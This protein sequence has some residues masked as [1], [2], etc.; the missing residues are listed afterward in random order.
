MRVSLKWL[1]DYVKLS[2]PAE[3]LAAKLTMSG[4]EVGEIDV[5]GATW[6]GVSVGQVKALE[7]HPDAD[8]LLLATIDIGKETITVVTGAPNLEA[9]QKVPFARVGTQL[10]DGHTGKLI[11]LKPATI[12][13][14][15]S[16]GMACSEKELGISERHEGIMVLPEEA[17]VGMPLS[18]YLGDTIIDIT[19]TPNRPDCLSVIGIAREVAALTGHEAHIPEITYEEQG[20]PIQDAASVEIDDPD[21]CS[22]YCASLV[23]GVTVGP[24]PQWMQQRII[25]SGMRPISNIV[26]ITNYV[27]MEYGQPLHAFDYEQIKERKIIVRRARDDESLYTLDGMK[28]ELNSD[29]LIIADATEPIALAGVMGGADSEVID[30]TTSILLES[31]NFNAGSIRRTSMRLGLRSEASARFERSISPELAPIALRR[32]TQ[33]LVELGGGKAARGI[34]DVYPGKSERKPILLTQERVDRILGVA[35]ETE[36]VRQVLTSLGFSSEPSGV[37][38]ELLVTVPY[39]RTDIRLA[40]DLIEEIARIIGYDE[41][42]TTMLSSGIPE[43]APAPLLSLKETIRDLLVGSG[44][45]EVITYSLVSRATLEKIDPQQKLGS[46]LRT[47][48]PMTLEQEY[49]RTSLR[50]GLLATFSANER[51][52]E[53]GIKLFEVGKIYLPKQNDLP[54]EREALA[55]ILGGTRLDRSW[56]SGE[57]TLDFFDAKGIVETVFNRLHVE[58]SF[59]PAEAQGLIPGR[60]A[61]VIVDG[62]QLGVLGEVHPKTAALFDISTEPVVLFEIDLEKLLPFAGAVPRYQP[63]PRLPAIDRDLALV[64][65][66][67][68]AANQI[69]A[70]IRSFPLVSE[71]TLFDVYSGKQVPEGKKSLAFSVR[72]RSP[73]RTLTDEEVDRTQQKILEHLEREFG[74]TLRS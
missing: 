2:V 22:R 71:V 3:E 1:K 74:A 5:V 18:Q 23:T 17:P 24:S 40:D 36:R 39:W 37:S 66:A 52:E 70:I 44:M 48:N 34:I 7:K 14:I 15:R 64:V 54:E 61:A 21:L 32:A 20:A 53:D 56:L 16:E 67:D 50:G 60:T 65:D 58:A 68:I 13:G 59:Q 9:G 33:L 49:L 11:K 35:V 30:S 62:Q 46:A 57:E 73:Q 42:P 38:S 8:R 55:G 25:A 45:Q 27:M 31:A 63:L 51:H 26:D 29:M 4:N 6:E 41:I 28:R 12:R 10:I 43:R 72:Y 47:A 19:T 69:Q